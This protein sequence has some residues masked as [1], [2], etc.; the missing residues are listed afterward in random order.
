[1]YIKRTTLFLFLC[2]C[3]LSAFEL[4]HDYK[5][6]SKA[7]KEL[8]SEHNKRLAEAYLEAFTQSHDKLSEVKLFL[9]EIKA[10]MQ[11]KLGAK[12]TYYEEL[13]KLGKSLPQSQDDIY[14]FAY[15]L[16]Y[17]IDLSLSYL[18]LLKKNYGPV[19]MISTFK[20]SESIS[21]TSY[22][23]RHMRNVS[24]LTGFENQIA[25]TIQQIYDFSEGNFDFGYQSIL[26]DNKKLENVS[27]YY[28]KK[29][30]MEAVVGSLDNLYVRIASI[31]EVCSHLSAK[32]SSEQD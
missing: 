27:Q 18:D 20:K 14:V 19:E 12:F 25:H 10:A 7:A 8:L 31:P 17:Q 15:K 32:N 1:M 4:E 3:S 6:P 9:L 13:K 5:E 16:I 28:F 23:A 2:L 24:S 29:E 11:I 30:S 21:A 26:G 22:L